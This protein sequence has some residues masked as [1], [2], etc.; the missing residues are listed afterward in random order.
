MSRCQSFQPVS[1]KRREW[2]N[3][4]DFI[5]GYFDITKVLCPRRYLS[6]WSFSSLLILETTRKISG[7]VIKSL[8]TEFCS[9]I[10]P[11]EGMFLCLF[12]QRSIWLAENWTL[13]GNSRLTSPAIITN[14]LFE[15]DVWHYHL[16]SL[17]AKQSFPSAPQPSVHI[18]CTNLPPTFMGIQPTTARANRGIKYSLIRN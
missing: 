4:S 8:V 6:R 13:S 17:W 12:T 18:T 1:T 10:F 7:K 14:H 16:M 5:W 3:Y 2:Q 9:H 11:M 15:N